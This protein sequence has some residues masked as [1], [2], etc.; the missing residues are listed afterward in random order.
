MPGEIWLLFLVGFLECCAVMLLGLAVV[1][2]YPSLPKVSAVAMLGAFAVL[3]LRHL[4]LSFSLHAVPLVIFL[5]LAL[6]LFLKVNF[7]KSLV[8]TLLGS[9][10]LALA[11]RVFLYIMVQLAVDIVPSW[12]KRK[13]DF[14]SP[15]LR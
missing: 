7:V 11:E 14:I 8:A 6:S 15:Y 4:S 3:Y 13:P 2:E 1:G 10:L 9:L 12:P 5:A